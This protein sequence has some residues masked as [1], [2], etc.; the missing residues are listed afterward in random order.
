[1]AG[2]LNVGDLLYG[3]DGSGLPVLN[4]TQKDEQA[5]VYNFEVENAHTYYVSQESILVHNNPC[6]EPF[7]PIDLTK[8]G[9]KKIR[10]LTNMKD[11][12]AADAIRARG[13]GA[14]QINQLQTGY[15]KLTVGDLANKAA[16]G[17]RAAETAIKIIKQASKKAQKY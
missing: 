8:G 12:K 9:A 13:G 3:I 11:M 1:M 10:N 14:S 4:V 6:A 5:T 7:G 16:A 15:E 17:D 2:Q